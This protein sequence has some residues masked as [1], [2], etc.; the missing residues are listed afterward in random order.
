MQYPSIIQRVETYMRTV[1]K[2]LPFCKASTDGRINSIR[3]ETS[4]IERLREAFHVE[5]PTSTRHWYDVLLYPEVENARPIPINIKVSCGGTDNALDKKAIVYSFTIL[6]EDQI[7]GAMS[8]NGM[9]QLVKEYR[10]RERDTAKEYYYLYIDKNDGTVVLR[11]ICDIQ[12][13]VSNPLNWMQIA[14][15]KEKSIQETLIDPDLDICYER[16]RKTLAASLM[17]LIENS[18]GL[19]CGDDLVKVQNMFQ[20][21]S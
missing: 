11:S 15:K 21:S 14:W 12:N 9:C 3:D 5:K 19:L 6:E 7:P 20:K 2:D 13:M 8:F 4:V 10:K 1:A 18:D 16:V 17:K